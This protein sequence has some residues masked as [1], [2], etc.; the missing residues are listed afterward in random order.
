MHN[1]Q[2]TMLIYNLQETTVSIWFR[3]PGTQAHIHLEILFSSLICRGFRGICIQIRC[4]RTKEWNTVHDW[5]QIC[6]AA[7]ITLCHN[8]CSFGIGK[9]HWFVCTS[10]GK[11][12]NG[13]VI[14]EIS[15]LYN[16][17]GGQFSLSV[18]YKIPYYCWIKHILH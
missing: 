11:C 8:L 1:W 14:C 12:I 2:V 3:Q 13:F 18:Q 6:H 15:F 16:E 5:I 10:T 4:K 7:T 17:L 9:K